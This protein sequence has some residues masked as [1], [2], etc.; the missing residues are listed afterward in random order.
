MQRSVKRGP[1]NPLRFAGP[2]ESVIA[3]TSSAPGTS[4]SDVIYPPSLGAAVSPWRRLPS[5]TL[6]SLIRTPIASGEKCQ[7]SATTLGLPVK[8][9][10]SVT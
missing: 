7:V 9:I 3:A 5:G 1:L 8:A 10:W 4:R 2:A 6:H